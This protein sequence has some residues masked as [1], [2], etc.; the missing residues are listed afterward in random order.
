MV[1]ARTSDI[2]AVTSRSFEAGA[3]TE[4]WTGRTAMPALADDF[5]TW[6]V[7]PASMAMSRTP[8]SDP[9]SSRM[10]GF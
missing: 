8:A 7:M 1:D 6:C 10:A 5:R 4:S 2:M 9:M 3:M